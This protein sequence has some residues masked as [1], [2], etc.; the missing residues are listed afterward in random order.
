M[1]DNPTTFGLLIHN[2]HLNYV[3]TINVT[4]QSIPINIKLTMKTKMHHGVHV[5]VVSVI[6]PTHFSQENNGTVLPG[7]VSEFK[8]RRRVKQ[9]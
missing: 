9:S 7:V 4:T 2:I 8:T 3:L 6:A 5:F 1:A